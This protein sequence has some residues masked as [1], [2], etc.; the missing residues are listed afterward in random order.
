MFSD[1]QL[2]PLVQG[3]VPVPT[4]WYV[5]STPG[6]CF[7]RVEEEILAAGI[8]ESKT[9]SFPPWKSNSLIIEKANNK[10][11]KR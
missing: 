4:N 7:S 2:H 11:L 6:G 1:S 9:P 8:L 10:C 3:D 5:N